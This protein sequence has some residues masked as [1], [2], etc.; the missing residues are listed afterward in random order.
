MRR[1]GVPN[2]YEQLKALTRGVTG[3]TRESLHAFIDGLADP[4]RRQG[5]AQGADAGDLRR[6]GRGAREARLTA[7]SGARIARGPA[8][9][10]HAA[11]ARPFCARR[12]LTNVVTAGISET[13]T[14]AN[15]I[16]VR[17]CLTHGMLPN[18]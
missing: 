8:G 11:P 7:A 13:T 3:M 4:C 16:S 12:S 17:F 6:Q 10:R 15:T 14:I 1:Y 2:P 5:A 18:R 9:A